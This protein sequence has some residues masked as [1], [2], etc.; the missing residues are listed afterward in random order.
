MMRWRCLP[1]LLSALLVASAGAFFASVDV[2]AAAPPPRREQL[3]FMWAM[4]G[5]ESG[6][7]YYAR[8][9]S[10]GAFG[11]YQIMPFNWPAWAER[12]LGDAEADQ[13]PFNQE[14]VA[15]GKIRDLYQWLGSW[16]RV[17]YWW[18]TGSSERSQRR[19]SDYARGYVDRI[20]ALRKRAP[21]KGS[22][23]PARTNS[24]V[25]PGQWR[26]SG[27]QQKLRLKV[28][29]R[30][31]PQG[32]RLRDGQVLKVRAARGRGGHRWLR[33]VTADGRLGWLRQ[34]ATVP[35]RR[36]AKAARWKDVVFTGPSGW[37]T[38]RRLV[39]PRPR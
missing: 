21:A 12:Y 28:A 31:W 15:F 1:V 30:V 24:K 22:D 26:R 9:A 20:M 32:G 27:S 7:D 25:K 11:K 6:W 33:V 34:T 10:S 19:W 8:N 35:A 18:L 17:A 38:D 2:E 4:A 23:W 13:T 5:Q 3:R 36:P 29:G 14:K 39:S 16:R 37:R